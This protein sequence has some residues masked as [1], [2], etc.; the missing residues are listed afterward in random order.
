MFVNVK[1]SDVLVDDQGL[2]V[3]VIDRITREEFT[4]LIKD[5]LDETITRCHSALAK[6]GM[7]PG[8]I[9]SVLLVGGSTYAKWVKEAVGAAFDMDVEPVQSRRLRSRGGRNRGFA[10]WGRGGRLRG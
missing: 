8:D 9:D 7:E 6:A 1:I 3:Q 10:A 4:E 2:N 5:E